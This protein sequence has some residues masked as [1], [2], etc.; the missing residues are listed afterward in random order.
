MHQT[1][2]LACACLLAA[3]AGPAVGGRYLVLRSPLNDAVVGQIVL[4]TADAC[5]QMRRVML[6]S[7][8]EGQR[9]VAERSKCEER[10]NVRMTS[11]AVFRDRISG[12]LY[13]I[14]TTTELLCQGMVG[15]AMPDA[16]IDVVSSCR[17]V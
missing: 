7:K 5:S 8:E 13:E 16:R 3:C 4:A 6:A 12:Y 14:E 1:I 11:R 17:D 15:G 9:V 2:L 10:S